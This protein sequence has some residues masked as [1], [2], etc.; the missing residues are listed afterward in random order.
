MLSTR[1]KNNLFLSHWYEQICSL[2]VCRIVLSFLLVVCCC[3][4]TLAV[5]TDLALGEWKLQLK[6]HQ[7]DNIF[8]IERQSLQSGASD[9]SG[10]ISR[11]K[12]VLSW[13]PPQSS[14]CNLS[15]FPNGTFALEGPTMA[16]NNPPKSKYLS[17]ESD[18]NMESS[19]SRRLSVHGRWFAPNN[20]YCAT[21]RFYQSI[22]LESFPRRQ[23]LLQKG[24]DRQ[25]NGDG[26]TMKT[27]QRHQLVLHGRLSG[28]FQRRNRNHS[29]QAVGRMTHGKIVQE[30]L[31]T[32]PSSG[33][34][35]PR[36]I[37]ASF[38]AQQITTSSAEEDDE[39]EE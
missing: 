38:V 6:S 21:D 24:L 3:W 14:E 5:D 30:N 37:V 11:R 36:P 32:P 20:P 29:S 7:L 17:V 12:R 26:T 16:N 15:I 18:S 1:K 4:P 31:S 2:P 34:Y 28:H 13:W 22:R 27:L 8:P 19:S 9:E 23:R 33:W 35:H 39:D 25:N 10:G